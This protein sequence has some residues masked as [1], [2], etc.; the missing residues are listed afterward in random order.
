MT[1]MRPT[2]RRPVASIAA[3]GML[4]L[5]GCSAP[6][7]PDG[8]LQRACLA[9][10]LVHR[11]DY[12]LCDEATAMLDAS[13]QAHVAAVIREYQRT[14]QAGV[15]VITHDQTL[16]DRW[17]DRIVDLAGAARAHA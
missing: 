17:S 7:T 5:A 9:R 15:L 6:A 2:F 16:L 11:P 10:A 4:V 13:T 8:Q 14:Q 12:L 1:R 3:A